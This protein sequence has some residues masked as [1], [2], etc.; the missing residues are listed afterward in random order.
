M[1]IHAC[2][3]VVEHVPTVVVRVFVNYEII[4]AVPAP[5]RA[6]RPIPIRHLEVR[7]SGKPEAVIVAVNPLDVIAVRRAE[8]FKTPV[9]E[10]WST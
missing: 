3:H 1:H 10:R 4:P 8:V 9:L 7:P 6:D 5:V 2:V